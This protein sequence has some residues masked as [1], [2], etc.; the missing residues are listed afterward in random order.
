L[1][2]RLVYVFFYYFFMFYHLK[3][4]R[5]MSRAF[6]SFSYF[7]KPEPETRLGLWFPLFLFF[8]HHHQ[9]SR[10]KSRVSLF[11]YF[12]HFLETRRRRVSGFFSFTLP[13]EG[14]ETC[15]SSPFLY[16]LHSVVPRDASAMR[17]EYLF[18]FLYFHQGSRRVSS[19]GFL[20]FLFLS[21]LPG[22]ETRLGPWISYSPPPPGLETRVSSPFSIF[23]FYFYF[24]TLPL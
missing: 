23:L 8:F 2:T 16:F 1:Q 24:L 5:R 15:V 21:P 13:A 14:L 6:F 4:S 22:P 7:T 12:V 19:P 3:G 17:L 18:H 10:C 20:F 11:F 9:G